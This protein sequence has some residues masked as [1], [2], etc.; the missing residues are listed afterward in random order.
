MRATESATKDLKESR[1]PAGHD[2]GMN[3]LASGD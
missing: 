1:S 3:L 2:F